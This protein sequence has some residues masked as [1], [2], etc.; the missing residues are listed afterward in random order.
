MSVDVVSSMGIDPGKEMTFPCKTLAMRCHF[1]RRSNSKAARALTT[2]KVSLL[3][4][5][6]SQIL[7][8]LQTAMKVTQ[9]STVWFSGRMGVMEMLYKILVAP[10]AMVTVI[11]WAWDMSGVLFMCAK[12]R[13]L[14]P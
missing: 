9:V 12:F 2:S 3:P 1:T 6:G 13:L 8:P 7:G 5:V 14:G 11:A 4:L 10:T